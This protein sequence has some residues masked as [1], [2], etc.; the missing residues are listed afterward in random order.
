MA[1]IY[2]SIYKTYIDQAKEKSIKLVIGE[3]KNVINEAEYL[4]N[5]Q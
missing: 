5:N 2:G 4:P 3:H 1:D